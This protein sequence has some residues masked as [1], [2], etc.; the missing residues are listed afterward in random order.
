MALSLVGAF[1]KKAAAVIFLIFILDSFLPERLIFFWLPHYNDDVSAIPFC[2][3]LGGL[4]AVYKEKIAI[5]VGVPIGFFILLL[6]FKGWSHEKYLIY[7]FI[8]M[9]AIYASSV[10]FIVKF[11]K[12]PDVS[13][14]VY[15]WGWPTQQVIDNFFLEI[16]IF[17]FFIFSLSISL[18]M[19]YIS[20]EL[21]EKRFIEI[22]RK[23]SNQF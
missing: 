19:A 9:I 1:N 12:I 16:K 4:M 5:T 8:F 10:P 3:A 15:L 13:Y 7:T 21:I 22:G 11:K 23:L 2:F 17:P 14:G 6:V 20:W 18:I